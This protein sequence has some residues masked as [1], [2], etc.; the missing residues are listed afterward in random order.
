MLGADEAA[1]K[2][3]QIQQLWNELQLTKLNSREYTELIHKIYARSVEY[4]KI[5]DSRSKPSRNAS[6]RSRIKVRRF[7]D[8]PPLKAYSPYRRNSIR[9]PS[10][11]KSS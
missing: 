10:P 6:G 1:K 3:E 2:L 4:Q 11:E 5:I 9:M 8:S 7:P